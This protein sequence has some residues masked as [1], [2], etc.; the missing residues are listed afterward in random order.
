M[1]AYHYV[2]GINPAE[3][4]PYLLIAGD[5]SARRCAFETAIAHYRQ[6]ISVLPEQSADQEQEFIEARLGLGRSLKLVGQFAEADQRFAEVLLALWRSDLGEN[7]TRLRPILHESL[8]QMADIRQRQGDYERAMAYLETS[9]QLLD[10]ASVAV[11][12]EL[13]QSLSDRMAWIRFRQGQ[14]AEARQLALDATTKPNGTHQ[15]DPIRLA[16]LYNTLGGISWQQGAF[17]DAVG[18]VKQSLELYDSVGY[19]WGTATAYGNLGV[20]YN[21]MGN[22]L[23]AAEYHER[24]Q[25]VHQIIGNPQGQAVSFDNLGILNMYLGKHEEARQDLS[26]GLSLRKR[27]GDSWGI[28][29]SHTNL[30]HLALIQADL[31][32]AAA[33]TQ[34]AL[35]MAEDIGSVEIRSF[36]SWVL[37]LIQAET[38]QLGPARQTVEEALDMAQSAGLLEREIE[39]WRVLGV[40]QTRRR[41]FD[42]AEASLR[43]SVELAI[44]QNHPYLQGQALCELGR[45]YLTLSQTDEPAAKERQAEARA[46]L[47]AAANLFQSLGAV[48]DLQLTEEMI[49]QIDW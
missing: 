15:A 6:A 4:V 13:W 49:N 19:H 22:W 20:L 40:V 18:Y 41:E 5:N 37:A 11:A 45:L 46:R 35:T 43:R 26:R 36:A 12:P 29:Q 27:L 10:Q 33:Q 24:A 39:C 25:A 16:S 7:P 34:E 28:A 17:D 9:L 48:H 3:G 47:R 31:E 32:E 14:L 30:A 2:Q 23:N 44:A 1:L 8:R 42:Q 21:S 38:D